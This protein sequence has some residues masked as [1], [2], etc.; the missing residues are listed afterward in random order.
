MEF[1]SPARFGERAGAEGVQ[2]H[3]LLYVGLLPRL[4][5]QR[6][7]LHG[8]LLLSQFVECAPGSALTLFE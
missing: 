1:S 6:V 3:G 5:A 7:V 8:P 4:W 2:E